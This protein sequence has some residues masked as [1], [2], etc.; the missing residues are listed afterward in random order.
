M[1]L[2]IFVASSVLFMLDCSPHIPAGIE[3]DPKDV[4]AKTSI[5]IYGKVMD[6]NQ[7]GRADVAVTLWRDGKGV[8]STKI[9]DKDGAYRFDEKP[10]KMMTITYFDDQGSPF[11]EIAQLSGT[12][13]QHINIIY[14]D[15]DSPTAMFVRLSAVE[16]LCVLVLTHEGKIENGRTKEFILNTTAQETLSVQAMKHMFPKDQMELNRMMESKLSEVT[17]LLKLCKKR[18]RD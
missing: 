4:N 9:T 15:V 8:Q 3:A 17:S 14:S 10:G 13:D 1:R 18:I 12:E 6:R 5:R 7:K 11:V 16:H 2:A